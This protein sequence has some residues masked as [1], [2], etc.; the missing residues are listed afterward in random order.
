MSNPL[1]RPESGDATR[2]ADR[3]E[4]I[5]RTP[6]MRLSSLTHEFPGISIYG[7][8]EWFNPGGSVKDRAAARIIV[9]AET[10]GALHPGKTIIDATSGNTGIA[11][12][13]IGAARGYPVRLVVPFNAGQERKQ[14]LRTYGAEITY[15][16]PTLGM[17]GAI[18]EAVRLYRE[19]RDTYF[20]ADQYGNPANWR[21]HYDGTAR[22]IWD[23]TDGTITHF[24]AGVGTSG[25]FVGTTRRLKTLNPSIKCVSVEPEGPFH[26]LEGL[27]HMTGDGVPG[28]YDRHL[29]DHAV[30]VRT[31]DAYRMARRLAQE[32]RLLVGP[33]SGAALV[34]SVELARVLRKSRRACIVTILCD[35]GERYLSQRFWENNDL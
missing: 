6:L 31:E 29:A 24:V 5:G 4:N 14:I 21:A 13:W 17:E 11:Y 9:D 35:S 33:S 26:G 30:Y 15:T 2:V 12:A 18:D 1:R 10:T 25:T 22:E 23:Q 27:K 8:A 7:K 28:I 16:D 20:Y 3:I 32:E 34:A 19:D